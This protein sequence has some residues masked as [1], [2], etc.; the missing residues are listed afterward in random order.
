MRKLIFISLALAAL[1][2]AGGSRE[3]TDVTLVQILGADGSK[4]VTLTAVGD[5]EGEPRYYETKGSDVIRAQ[6]ALREEGE[7]RLEVTHVAQLVLGPDVPVADVLWQEVTHRESGYGATIWLTEDAAAGELLREAADPVKRL[8]SMEDNGGVAAP[9]LLE[10]L[11]AL[12]R[13]G[14]VT[15]PVLGLE[16]E[17][18]RVVGWRTVEEE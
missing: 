9:T 2:V 16:G 8:R 10:A 1:L 14:R 11:S 4:P 7:T 17:T 6:E 15:L 12:T 5:E 3:L 18:L 13:E